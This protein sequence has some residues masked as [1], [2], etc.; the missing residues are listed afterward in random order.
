MKPRVPCWASCLSPQYHWSQVPVPAVQQ[1]MRELF[2]RWGLPQRLRVDHGAPWSTWADLPPA[3]VLWWLGLG[4]EPIFNHVHRPTE[5]ARVERCNGLI[6]PW[7]E[8]TS[9][10]DYPTWE[11][12]L[13][14]LAQVQRE[15]YPMGGQASRLAAHPELGAVQRPY[16]AAREGEQWQLARVWE[17][18]AA[19]RWPRVVSKIGQIHL[20]GQPY[21]VGRAYVRQTVWV[22]VDAERGEWVVQGPDG[23]EL[24]R[25]AAAQLTT[26][27]ICQ[28]QVAHPRPPSKKRK[29]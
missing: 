10:P 15:E 29:R 19:G 21:R 1:A 25:H 24:I 22:Q 4:I 2:E 20:Y 13:I 9:C 17:Y 11:R 23:Q 14:W 28:L 16:Q 7:G 3:L 27:R 6:E 18:L 8:P 5:N 26:A 12:R